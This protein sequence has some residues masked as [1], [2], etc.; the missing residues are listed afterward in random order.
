MREATEPLPQESQPQA[1]EQ[2]QTQPQS[3]E[4]AVDTPRKLTES[5]MREKILKEKVI[6]M[7]R[8]SMNFGVRPKVS[9]S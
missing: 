7:R 6:A 3:P 1:R 2:A 8:E 5:E 9:K 4:T